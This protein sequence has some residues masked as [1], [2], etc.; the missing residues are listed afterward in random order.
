M[1]PSLPLE[2]IEQCLGLVPV[3]YLVPAFALFRYLYESTQSVQA[4]KQQMRTLAE[5]CAQLLIA[6][7][8]QAKSLNL[9]DEHK[10]GPLEDLCM[11]V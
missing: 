6:L 11:S 2:A 9:S 3:P 8:R 7:D 10:K 5:N 1:P 4:S